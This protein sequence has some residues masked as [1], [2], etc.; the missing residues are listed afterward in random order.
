MRIRL[1]EGLTVEVP[2]PRPL[3]ISGT[4]RATS[5]FVMAVVE[6]DEGIRGVGYGLAR[7]GEIAAIIDHN[8]SPLLIGEDPLKIEWL[9]ER[10]YV[11]TRHIDRKGPVMRALSAVDIALWDI[12]AQ[13]AGLPLYQLLGGYHATVPALASG[14]SAT[15]S[16][17]DALAEE[18]AGYVT[19]GHAMVKIGV[20]VLTADEDVQRV[21]AVR[22][23]VGRQTKLGVDVSG[24]WQQPKPAI[25]L[26][27]QMAEYGLAFL[28][29]PF[30]PDNLPALKAFCTALDTPVAVGV[31]QSGRLVFRDLLIAGAVDVLRH[32][33]TVVGGISEWLKVTSLAAAWDVPVLP[34]AFPEIHVH[35]VAAVANGLAVE[36]NGAQTGQPTIHALVENPLEPSRGVLTP[37][38]QPG[39][40]LQWNWRAIER[41][42]VAG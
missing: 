35:L 36:V 5:N 29:E 9:W 11:S 32:D 2:L 31:S 1:V 4:T 26:A 3:T 18:M 13:V 21:E 33:A 23:A 39:L 15:S 42:R 6:T 7:D 24:A 14:G 22:S 38:T 37:P 8:L 41:F 25:K 12:K 34:H 40:G 28:E 19:A 16:D 30:G 20:G 10:M 27:R 17:V